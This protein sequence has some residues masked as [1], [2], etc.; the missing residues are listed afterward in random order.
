MSAWEDYHR[1]ER[2][3]GMEAASAI[4]DKINEIIRAGISFKEQACYFKALS[5]VQEVY[6]KYRRM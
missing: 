4:V 2:E 6:E 3:V 5:A 1:E